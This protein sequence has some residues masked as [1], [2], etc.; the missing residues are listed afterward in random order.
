MVQVGGLARLDAPAAS[1]PLM[2]ARVVPPSFPLTRAGKNTPLRGRPSPPTFSDVN[3]SQLTPPHLTPPH[4]TPSH[5]IASHLDAA[6]QQAGRA[7]DHRRSGATPPPPTHPAAPGRPLPATYPGSSTHPLPP[8]P[9]QVRL[10]CIHPY[11]ATLLLNH[12]S[13][14]DLIVVALLRTSSDG[15]KSVRIRPSPMIYPHNSY[16]PPHTPLAPI[17]HTRTRMQV[18]PSPHYV[19]LQGRQSSH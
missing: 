7:V 12:E 16:T 6:R 15:I 17:P 14:A 3:V 10:L 2:S 5:R 19:N 11:C 4:L 18:R 8:P 1:H 13:L 9:P